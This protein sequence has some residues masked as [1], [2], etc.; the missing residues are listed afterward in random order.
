[1]TTATF[2]QTR[3]ASISQPALPPRGLP[4]AARLTDLPPIDLASLVAAGSLQTRV[5]RKYLVSGPVEA[6]ALAQL[7]ASARVLEIAGRRRFSYRTVY[8]DTPEW[9]SYLAST[10]RRRRRYKVRTRTYLDADVCWLEVKTKDGRGRTVKTRTHHPLWADE[11]LAAPA[12][13]FLISALT[14][15][16]ADPAGEVARLAP[17]L[18]TH[19]QRATLFLPADGARATIDTDLVAL[20][21]LGGR[22]CLADQVIIETKSPSTPSAMDRTLWRLGQRPIKVSKYATSLA[23]LRP[24][25]PANKWQPALRRLLAGD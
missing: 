3:P 6:A 24:D 16:V 14:G 21:G 8:F 5:D 15:T 25:M 19:Y 1:M 4:P 7:T 13:E 11:T 10:R 23:V 17:V 18:S 22:L 12:P 2:P 9:S 20:D